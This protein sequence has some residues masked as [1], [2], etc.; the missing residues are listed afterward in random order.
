MIAPG[1]TIEYPV[2]QRRWILEDKAN[3]ADAIVSLHQ[4]S[5]VK[6]QLVMRFV[7]TFQIYHTHN[8]YH[9]AGP[10]CEML[11]S[12]SRPGFGIVLL[13]SEARVLP[14]CEHVLY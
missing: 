7:D 5:I 11:R 2:R 1:D 6:L 3:H 13:P 10:A 9:Q 8:L 4:R 12:L 14:L